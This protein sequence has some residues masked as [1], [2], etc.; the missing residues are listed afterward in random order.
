M[1]HTDRISR[2]GALLAATLLA[3]LGLLVPGSPAWAHNALAAAS[4]AKKA[5]LKK[6]PT[7]VKLRF[8]Q[9]LD[10]DYTTITVSD[11]SKQKVA[12]SAPKVSG[13]TGT[14]TFTD[15]LA[16]GA[17]TVA[18]QVVSTDG[19]TVKGSYE[20][21]VDDPSAVAPSPSPTP[22]VSSA[23]PAPSLEE[24]A[25]T[26]TPDESSGTGTFVGV[27]VGVL[28]VLAGLAGFLFVRRRKA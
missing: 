1:N 14:V 15:T 27:V 11:A 28:V 25:V 24:K 5:T 18:Y 16:N 4:P 7:E 19:H 6:A 2:A 9:K 21:T 26:A 8:L 23:A 13:Q 22:V 10:P 3:L 20:F 17:Y 12:T